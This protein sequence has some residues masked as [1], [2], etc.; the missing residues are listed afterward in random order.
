MHSL[1]VFFQCA[2]LLVGIYIYCIILYH[3]FFTETIVGVNKYKL[4]KEDEVEVLM[5]DNSK[6]RENQVIESFFE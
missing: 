2:F 3:F 1:Y 4:E 6:V 5:V